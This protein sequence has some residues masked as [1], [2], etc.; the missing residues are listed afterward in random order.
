MC[1]RDSCDDRRECILR[2]AFFAAELGF[3]AIIESEVDSKKVRKGAYQSSTWS[4]SALPA[5]VDGARLEKASLK[6][7]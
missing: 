7:F 3:N 5:D 2:L 4:G 6:G 1:I